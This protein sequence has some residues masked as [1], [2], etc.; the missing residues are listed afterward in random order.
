MM[1][2]GLQQF[3]QVVVFS[4]RNDFRFVKKLGNLLAP[5]CEQTE[6]S[7]DS[8]QLNKGERGRANSRPP[9]PLFNML[10]RITGT[11]R[12]VRHS[13]LGFRLFTLLGRNNVDCCEFHQGN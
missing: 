2:A 4:S 11:G 8:W 9:L 1:E 5:F 6:V 13:H 7:T 12:F 10:R 3:R